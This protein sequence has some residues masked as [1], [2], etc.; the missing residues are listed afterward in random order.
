MRVDGAMYGVMSIDVRDGRI[1]NIYIQVN[2]AKLH[3][4]AAPSDAI[5]EIATGIDIRGRECYTPR[6]ERTAPIPGTGR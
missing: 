6:A 1:Q 3:D 2:P 5:A 4:H